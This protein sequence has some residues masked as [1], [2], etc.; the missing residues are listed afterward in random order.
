MICPTSLQILADTNC[1]NLIMLN[2]DIRVFHIDFRLTV[3]H[4]PLQENSSCRTE[5]GQKCF[6]W[7]GSCGCWCG[8]HQQ[9][10]G[11]RRLQC[12]AA[13]PLINTVPVLSVALKGHMFISPDCI[14]CSMAREEQRTFCFS[15]ITLTLT[16]LINLMSVSSVHV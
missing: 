15:S 13:V 7:K 12:A 6:C 14:Q 2:S 8:A 4:R 5:M 1:A 3:L 9:L 10:S 11:S 16:F